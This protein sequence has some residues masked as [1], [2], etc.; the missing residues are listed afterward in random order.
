MRAVFYFGS[1]RGLKE[2]T[3]EAA[4]TS[5]RPLILL[6]GPLSARVAFELPLAFD[7]KILLAYP[8][9]PSDQ[10]AAGIDELRRLSASH[11]LEKHH[12]ATRISALVAAKVLVEGLRRSG[13]ALSRAKLVSA[14]EGLSKFDTGLTP[15]I[16]FGQSRHVGARGA[17]VVAIDLRR[18][19]FAPDAAWIALD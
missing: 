17:H 13:R 19:A 5:W 8:N 7:G 1:E 9:L 4:K 2:F 11:G 14:L 10:S 12:L 16:S 15:P 3:D 6:S 18:R